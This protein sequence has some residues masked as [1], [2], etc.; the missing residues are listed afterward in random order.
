MKIRTITI[1]QLLAL[2]FLYTIFFS[3][4]WTALFKIGWIYYLGFLILGGVLSFLPTNLPTKDFLQINLTEIFLEA[5]KNLQSLRVKDFLI[6][7]LLLLPCG[8][9][10]FITWDQEF[11]FSGDHDFHLWKSFEITKFWIKYIWTIVPHLILGYWFL[12]KKYSSWWIFSGYLLVFAASLILA[13]TFMARYPALSYFFSSHLMFLAQIFNWDSP[14]NALRLNNFLSLLVWI[15]LLRPIFLKAKP[16]LSLLFLISIFFMQK[17]VV[18]YF[19]SSYLEPLCL[20]FVLMGIETLFLEKYQDYRWAAIWIGLAALVKE[21]GI[22]LLPFVFLASLTFVRSLRSL[23]FLL[24]TTFISGLPFLY[25]YAFRKHENVGRSSYVL[26]YAQLISKEHI[27]E[28]IKRFQLQWHLS[29][30]IAFLI[31]LICILFFILYLIFKV[32]NYRLSLRFIFILLG[33][34]TGIL[35]FYVDGA[36]KF[37]TGYPRFN[38]LGYTAIFGLTIP[39]CKRLPNWTIIFL[40]I[41][42][43]GLSGSPLI[44]AFADAL[45][46]SPFRNYIEH[47]EAPK[48]LSINRSLKLVQK[49]P[50]WSTEIK[51]LRIVVKLGLTTSTA[52]SDA[53]HNIIKRYNVTI[54]GEGDPSI[55]LCLN[56]NGEVEKDALIIPAHIFAGLNNNWEDKEIERKKMLNCL[57]SVKS[58]CENVFVD[59]YDG[60]ILSIVGWRGKS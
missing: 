5:K 12:G 10:L 43:M 24:L 22:L 60:E 31:V 21:Q 59:W 6:A 36:S 8:I 33:A 51:N 48:F 7:A 52:L 45:K 27:H 28:F 13:P 53:Y 30:E 38:L 4:I 17:D 44:S 25:Y 34:L 55:C 15:F 56:K 29:G 57:E 40:G 37:W 11:P 26:P 58:S 46:P 50:R 19:T 39:L 14:L 18:Y 1:T 54:V 23:F 9:Y 3:G 41:L 42:L 47:Y 20:V 49:D 16:N 2:F 32:K 35:F